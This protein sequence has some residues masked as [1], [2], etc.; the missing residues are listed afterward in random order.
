INK[1]YSLVDPF[2]NKMPSSGSVYTFNGSN[3][4]YGSDLIQTTP[5][6]LKVEWYLNGSL[7]IN[8][9]NNIENFAFEDF[10][11]GNNTL[12]MK[13][14]DQTLMSRSYL[15]DDGYEFFLS[16]MVTKFNLCGDVVDQYDYRN[17]F[18]PGS[19]AS[20]PQGDDFDWTEWSGPTP[21]SGTGPS[22]AFD[23]NTYLYVEATGHLNAQKAI[24]A[25][26]CFDISN[27]NKPV[28]RI[29]HHLYGQGIGKL[30]IAVSVNA[31]FSFT[32]VYTIEGNQGNFWEQAEIDL[33]SYKSPYTRFA[34]TA[35]TGD[36]FQ[37]DIAIDLMEIID[38]CPEVRNLTGLVHN[39]SETFKAINTL[40]STSTANMGTITYQ[41]GT[42]VNLNNGFNV[43]Q[44][45]T[46][47]AQ[48]GGCN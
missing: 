1:I 25:T 27:L 42:S 9:T 46:F 31:G 35:T 44:G 40:S 22:A 4:P 41:A 19:G 37:G 24:F 18:P 5:N 33:S 23:G 6:S 36:N 11:D 48:I 15:P 21:S 16:W 12:V 17:S 39:H 14:I 29:Y 32:T 20:Q 45:V 13:V 30:E 38:V 28:F 34:I 10:S 2:K 8:R 26:G 43:K 3:T 7:L 47:N